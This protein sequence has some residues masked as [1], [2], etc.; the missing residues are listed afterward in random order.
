MIVMKFGGTSVQD[1]AAI[2][3][4]A[5]IVLGRL[6]QRPAVVVSAFAGVTDSLLTMS[7]DAASGQLPQALDLLWQIRQRHLGVLS[8]LVSDD[9][10]FAVRERT[11]QLTD[12]LQVELQGVATLGELSART[13]DAILSI[14]ELLSS[15]IVNAAFQSRGIDSVLV[16]SRRCLVTDAAHTCA[17]P[18]CGQTNE[19]W[20]RELGPLLQARQAR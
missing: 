7:K 10:R 16:D 8:S 20:Q 17:V 14:G 5:G 1:G 9:N 12:A 4:A 3:R 19:R 13:T 11:C 2:E 15:A 18:C 6:E